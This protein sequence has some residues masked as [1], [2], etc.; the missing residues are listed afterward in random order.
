MRQEHLREFELLLGWDATLTPVR[1]T[2]DVVTYFAS[3]SRNTAQL[4]DERRI[5][6]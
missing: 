1:H 6:V 3:N 4:G 5:R 2:L